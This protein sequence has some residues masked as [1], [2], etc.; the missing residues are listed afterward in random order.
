MNLRLLVLIPQSPA[1]TFLGRNFIL[2]LAWHVVLY[3]DFV[4]V[5]LGNLVPTSC[6]CCGRLPTGHFCCPLSFHTVFD[7]SLLRTAQLERSGAYIYIQSTSQLLLKGVFGPLSNSYA[8]I[9]TPSSPVS[10]SLPIFSYILYILSLVLNLKTAAP[11]F[12]LLAILCAYNPWSVSSLMC[13][14]FAESGTY[15]SVLEFDN[16]DLFYT[17]VSFR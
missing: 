16:P 5:S 6:L 9:F 3:S 4:F 14:G 11:L 17:K 12:S 8:F 1:R 15:F 2:M 13:C 7:I 10:L